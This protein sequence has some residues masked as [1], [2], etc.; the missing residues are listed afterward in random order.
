MLIAATDYLWV[1]HSHRA[2]V[3][4]D[5]HLP[6]KE[7]RLG[8]VP[9]AAVSRPLQR[10]HRAQQRMPAQ[11]ARPRCRQVATFDNSH[12]IAVNQHCIRQLMWK[13]LLGAKYGSLLENVGTPAHRVV[14][15]LSRHKDPR[16]CAC[17]AWHCRRRRK[18][19][20]R[21]HPV[22]N[23]EAALGLRCLR[24]KQIWIRHGAPPQDH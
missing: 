1:L 12:P 13:V 21:H 16:K 17:K 23:F 9:L 22:S 4:S 8:G 6:K 10:M 11:P 20:D 18:C 24:S 7:S 14:I 5:A 19:Q 3:D 2:S 15:T